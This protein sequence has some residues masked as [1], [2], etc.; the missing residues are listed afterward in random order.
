MED[1][2]NI[3]PLGYREFNQ[4]IPE[5]AVYI[6]KDYLPENP[7]I[8]EAGA[9]DGKESIMLASLI[10]NSQIYCFE[11]IKRLFLNVRTNTKNYVNI[12]SFNMGLGSHTGS[13]YMFL[14][15]DNGKVSMSS[16]LL[17]PKEHLVYSSTS[18]NGKERISVITLDD[19][20]EKHKIKKIDLLW[21]DLQGAELDVL[22]NGEKI[23]DTVSAIITEVE[24][25]EAYEGQ[26]LYSHI[27]HYLESKGF[28]LVAGNFSFPKK[29]D[30]WFGDALFI[31]KELLK[32]RE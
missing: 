32:K 4:G 1:T 8:I 24:F 17:K 3:P 31:K 19:W 12:H 29:P 28:E 18:F 2:G 10:P 22:K 9:Y 25:V 27:K 16:S 13:S 30:Q 11:P 26:P 5:E 23:L 14:S 15:Y 20:S 7:T 21:L 6:L